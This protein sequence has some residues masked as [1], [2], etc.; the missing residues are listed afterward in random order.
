[1]AKSL[2][3]V[4]LPMQ[5]KIGRMQLLIT[6]MSKTHTTHPETAP[7]FNEFMLSPCGSLPE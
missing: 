7:V 1:M 5:K 6:P 4:T 3:E 2:K